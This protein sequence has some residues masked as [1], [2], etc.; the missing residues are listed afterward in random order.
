VRVCFTYTLTITPD[1][2]DEKEVTEGCFT[3]AGFGPT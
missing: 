2:F 1:E 3:G